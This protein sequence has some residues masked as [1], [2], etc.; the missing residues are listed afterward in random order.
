MELMQSF[1]TPAM[2]NLE[3]NQILHNNRYRIDINF[4]II[5]DEL[6]FLC[7]IFFT[8]THPHFPPLL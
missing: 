3:Y 4:K 5:N 8:Q 7:P 6:P 2:S 1:V